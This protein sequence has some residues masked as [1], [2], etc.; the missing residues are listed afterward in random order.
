MQCGVFRQ[1]TAQCNQRM[2]LIIAQ[3]PVLC[4]GMKINE[5]T[6]LDRAERFFEGRPR[7]Y[8]LR[9]GMYLTTNLLELDVDAGR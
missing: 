7:L 1:G 8:L 3:V 4:W 9:N 5:I 6:L 2:G